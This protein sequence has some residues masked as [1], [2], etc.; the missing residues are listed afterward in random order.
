MKMENN[1]IQNNERHF[2]EPFVNHTIAPSKKR[3][4]ERQ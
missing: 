2:L 4:I 1:L 3:G